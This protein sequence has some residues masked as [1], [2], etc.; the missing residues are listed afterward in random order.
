MIMRR[1]LI[2]I[3]VYALNAAIV[4]CTP[5]SSLNDVRQQPARGTADATHTER[6][7]QQAQELCDAMLSADY[8]KAVKLTY[9]KLV[10]LMGGRT[11]FI[12]AVRNAMSQTQS[13]QFRIESVT[14]G[15]PRD[16]IQVKTEKY[17]I[18]PT[19]MKM[20]VPE[21]LLVGEAFMIGISSDGGRNWTFVDS[22]GRSMDKTQLMVLFPSAAEKLRL[23]EVKKP[24]LYRSPGV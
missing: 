22:G 5:V 13:A 17:V 20:K 12:A 18:V 19:T 6:I 15:E 16:L 21:G 24:T 1:V 11:N 14:V 2:L 3:A 9:P 8:D 7:K 4:I 23:P 10:E